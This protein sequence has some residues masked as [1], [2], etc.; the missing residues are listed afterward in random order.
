MQNES[1]YQFEV[2]YDG[3]CPL[4]TR[5]INFLRRMDK[6]DSIVAT[7]ISD[8]SFDAST[9]GVEWSDLMD[10]IHGRGADGLIVEGVEVFRRLYAAVGWGWLVSITRVP[11]IRQCLDAAYSVF[12]RNRL[13]LTNRSAECGRCV[14]AAS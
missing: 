12:A 10:R 8:P 7:D 4:C 1:N 14:R 2:F 3:G 5:E 6:H 9:T 11:G 13:R